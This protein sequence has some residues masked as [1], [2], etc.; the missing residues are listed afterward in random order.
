M[1]KWAL[2]LPL[3]MPSEEPN[4]V[5]VTHKAELRVLTFKAQRERIV[6]V[7]TGNMEDG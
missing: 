4:V 5:G 6:G 2:C 1:G 7:A 3:R